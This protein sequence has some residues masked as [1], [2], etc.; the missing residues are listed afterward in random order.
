MGSGPTAQGCSISTKGKDAYPLTQKGRVRGGSW[1][2]NAERNIQ[3]PIQRTLG[4]PGKEET[5]LGGIQARSS[6]GISGQCVLVRITSICCCNKQAPR[7]FTLRIFLPSFSYPLFSFLFSF[8]NR[9]FLG[10]PSCPKTHYVA[11]A[12]FELVQNTP[13]LTSWV[14][15]L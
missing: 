10:N 2:R 9:V 12:G 8:W 11:Q 5:E 13:A 1:N 15:G 14:L 3:K 4:S 7:G 6:Q